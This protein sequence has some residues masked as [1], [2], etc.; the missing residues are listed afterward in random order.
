M[1][2]NIVPLHAQSSATLEGRVFDPSGALVSGTSILM[3][4]RA[5]GTE[6]GVV[7]DTGG[8]YQIVALPAGEYRVEVRAPRFNTQILERLIVEAARTIVQDFHLALGNV[9]EDITVAARLSPIDRASIAVGHVMNERLV[10]DLPLNGRRFVDL[11]FLLPGSVTPAQGGYLTAPSRG[12]GFYGFNTAGSR[13]DAVNVLV[14]GV[15]VNEQ[16]NDLTLQTSVSTVQE[17]KVDNSTFSAQYG[18]NSGAIVNIVTRSGTNTVR[19]EAFE[20]FRDDALDARNFFNLTGAPELFRRHQFGAA[21]GGPLVRNR[22][23]LF[24][25]YDGQRQ[26]QGLDVNSLVLSDAERAAVRAPQVVELLRFIPRANLVDARGIPRFVGFAIA[27]FGA[28]QG[29]VDLTVTP[30]GNGR[31]HAYYWHFRDQR[32]EPLLQGNTIPGFGDIRRRRRHVFTLNEMRVMGPALVN[33]ARFGVLN[34]AGRASPAQLL[35]PTEFGI[36][37]GVEEPIGL[38]QISVGGGLNFGGPANFLMGRRG[39]TFVASDTISYQRP[40][41]SLRL[42]S[43][44]RWYT[45]ESYTRDPGRFNFPA[46]SDFIVGTGN[47]FS[48]ILGDRSAHISQDAVGLFV[49]DQF[50]LRPNLTIEFGLRYD[51]TLSPTE[52]DDRFVVFDPRS[53]ALV[54]VGTHV[55]EIYQ[56]N[57]DLQPRF[58]IAW[59]PSG[60]GGAVVRAAYG[61]Y[62]NQPITNMLVGATANPPLVT[63]LTYSGPIGLDNAVQLARAAG[64]APSTVDPAFENAT[65]Q[66][67]NV[68]VQREVTR[69]VAV[70]VGYFGARGSDLRIA[71]NINQPIDGRRP[72]PSLLESSPI[73]PGTSLG[74][75]TQIESAGRS[76]YRALWISSRGR[77]SDTLQLTASYT[78]A[79]STDY[80]SLNT[81]G[82]VVQ[83]G[84]DLRAE[85]GPSDYDARHR[86]VITAI[87]QLPLRGNKLVEGWQVAAIVQAQSGSPV[88]IVTSNSTL[89]GVANT[90]WPD[91]TGP[92]RT[93]G[94]LDTWFDTSVFVAANHFG[95]LGRN[96]VVGPRFDNTDL[97]IAKTTAMHGLRLEL[98]AEL[99]NLFNHP[100]FGQPGNVVGSP[101]LGVITSTRFPTGELGS[102][103]QI[104]FAAKLIF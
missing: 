1:L 46:V 3:R 80:N 67:W 11:G 8:G 7:T 43:E 39:W 60:N 96:A 32:S 19:G 18:R 30:S 12:D 41:H 57:T 37:V 25:A 53:V 2:L 70:M 74:N 77:L 44:Y 34:S 24:A 63:P 48:V 58:G 97:S 66:S 79:K 16:F 98:R 14:N 94:R 40:R 54:R 95:N 62:I 23:F 50:G 10:Q 75:V 49:Q 47:A 73:L 20:F 92:V 45:N 85:L 65:T 29:S 13:E 55:D 33:E 56:S 72:F 78:L 61:V 17:L 88:N 87:Y 5:T 99:F 90:V 103:R 6:R 28:N 26:R 36:H 76:S 104:Q 59:D 81:Q 35:D 86:A 42:G 71:R 83:N 64:L 68:N 4:H 91:V 15:T 100:N 27:P 38:P 84:Y 101:N 89:N 69:N 9:A 31:L 93:I 51:W 22:L 82:V 102:S 21:V 52:R